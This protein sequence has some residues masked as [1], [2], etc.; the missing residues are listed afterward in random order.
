M[1]IV[2]TLGNLRK[3]TISKTINFLISKTG[4]I[5][6]W[7]RKSNKEWHWGIM[8]GKW[9]MECVKFMIQEGLDKDI[10]FLKRG[11]FYPEASRHFMQLAGIALAWVIS[12]TIVFVDPLIML[13]PKERRV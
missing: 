1:T 6:N 10:D 13:L 8:K 4:N 3:I 9:V 12:E 2:Q 5:I 7:G 11:I